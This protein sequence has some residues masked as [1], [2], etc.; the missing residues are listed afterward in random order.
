VPG[1]PV[2]RTS[3]TGGGL[4]AVSAPVLTREAIFDGLYA[5]K[6]YAATGARIY[7]RF[8]INGYDMGSEI[9]LAESLRYNIVVGGTDGISSVEIIS[10]LRESLLFEYTGTDYVELAE[11][12]PAD[13]QLKWIY[14]RVVQIDRHMAWSSPIWIG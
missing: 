9:P 10:N 7:L 13:R 12:L 8:Q 4:A 2:L 5:R 6:C 1:R 11:E 14:I 3:P